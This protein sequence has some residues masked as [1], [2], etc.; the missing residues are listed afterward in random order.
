MQRIKTYNS[1][2]H[3]ISKKRLA[4]IESGE[5]KQTPRTRLNAISTKQRKKISEYRHIAFLHRGRKCF[6]C[7]RA[8]PY[9]KLDVHHKDC[10]RNNN[11]PDN[12]FPLCNRYYGCKAHNHMGAEGLGELN[13]KIEKAMERAKWQENPDGLKK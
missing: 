9:T 12:L 10:N 11:T 8:E 1:S 2:L 7:G 6:L 4:A 13:A 5:Y 3:N